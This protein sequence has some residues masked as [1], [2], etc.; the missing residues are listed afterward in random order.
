M[1]PELIKAEV[2]MRGTTPA[3][4]A[5]ELGV[6]R[7]LVTH[8]INGTGKSARIA[9]HLAKLLG[10]PVSTLW[11]EAKQRRSGLRRTKATA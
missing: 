2:R 3:A 10:K 1:H 4:I 9:E 5:D 7:S 11:P 8:V 6:S